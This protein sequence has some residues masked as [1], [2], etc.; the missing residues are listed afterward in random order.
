MGEKL[1]W[2]DFSF[3]I[4]YWVNDVNHGQVQKNMLLYLKL[5][6]LD[7][8]RH[9]ETIDVKESDGK[10]KIITKFLL[11][12]NWSQ[13]INTSFIDISDIPL[14]FGPQST[15][16]WPLWRH[17]KRQKIIKKDEIRNYIIEKGQTA[18]SAQS[19]RNVA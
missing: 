5:N 12:F 19:N 1:T 2:H 9:T 6:F 17:T 4:M 13:P 16:H 14:Y 15:D 8:K 3:T 7:L 11:S 18:K 10:Q